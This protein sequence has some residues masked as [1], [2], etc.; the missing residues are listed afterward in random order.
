MTRVF[1]TINNM[2][3]RQLVVKIAAPVLPLAR[4]TNFLNRKQ[5]IRCSQSWSRSVV[6]RHRCKD[7]CQVAS[8]MLHSKHRKWPGSRRATRLLHTAHELLLELINSTIMFPSARLWLPAYHCWL[9][10][11]T[12]AARKSAAGRAKDRSDRDQSARPVD[13]NRSRGNDPCSSVRNPM[14]IAKLFPSKDSH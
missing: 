8:A 7:S 6:C 4:Y 14:H 5:A 2:S 11:C 3:F 10:N 13:G 12:R 1:L 9:S